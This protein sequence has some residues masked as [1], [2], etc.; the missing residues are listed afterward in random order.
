MSFFCC[1]STII[2]LFRHKNNAIILLLPQ[3]FRNFVGNL[4]NKTYERFYKNNR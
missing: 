2:F 4:Y 3:K 1:K